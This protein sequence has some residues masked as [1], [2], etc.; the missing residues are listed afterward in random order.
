MHARQRISIGAADLSIFGNC[1][2][3]QPGGNV[4]QTIIGLME[5]IDAL[6]EHCQD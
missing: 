5:C 4:I 1:G 3:A 6:V 2:L